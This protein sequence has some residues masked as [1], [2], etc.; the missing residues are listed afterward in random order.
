MTQIVGS[1][2][3][4][5]G[6]PDTYKIIGAAMEVHRTLGPGFLEPV[7]QL[8]FELE[9]EL[10]KVPFVREVELAVCYKETLLDVRYRV[11]FVCFDEILVELKALRRLSPIEE[12]QIIHYLVAS[13]LRRGILL[14]FGAPSL[15]FRRFVGP[16]AQTASP[17]V[18]SVKSVDP[19]I[20]KP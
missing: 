10:R 14:N 1:G 19:W 16:T 6:D 20:S 11:D 15:Q 8:A 9:L 2:E 5:D 12:N 4:K 3:E 17:S 13:K 7:Y 18:Q